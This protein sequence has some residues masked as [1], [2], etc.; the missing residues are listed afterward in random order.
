MKDV[1]LPRSPSTNEVDVD[2]DNQVIGINLLSRSLIDTE[3]L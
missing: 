3:H 2:R 1:E